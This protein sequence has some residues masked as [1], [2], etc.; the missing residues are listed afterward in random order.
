MASR[1]NSSP[2]DSNKIIMNFAIADNFDVITVTIEDGRTVGSVSINLLPSSEVR[3]IN[4]YS[5]SS[6]SLFDYGRI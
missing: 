4:C 1:C 5:L 2:K 3:I 6:I